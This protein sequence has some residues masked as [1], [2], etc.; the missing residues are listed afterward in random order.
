MA[1]PLLP[2]AE[3]LTGLIDALRR[4]PGVGVRSARRMAYHLLQHDLQGAEALGR[5]L[6][7]ATTQLRH[8]ARCNS[9]TEDEVCAV[10]L[11]PRRDASV[12]CIVETPA[13]Q[14]VIEAS[15]GYRGLYFVLMG[16]VAPLEGIGA[17]ELEFS[18]V[19]ARACDGVV[20]EVIL[21]T[22]FT[23]EGETTAHL[24]GEA[25]A[26]KG[27]KITRLARGVP[28]GGELEYVDAGTIAWALME[29]RNAE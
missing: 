10:C 23:A 8:C 28:A 5:A 4:L 2:E 18:R 19:V 20:Q 11:N 6:S 27:V 9:F 7:H 1:D 12:L 29:R 25:L 21:A 13:D 16:R 24:L 26:G 17:L 22:N 3:P 15:H 14:N